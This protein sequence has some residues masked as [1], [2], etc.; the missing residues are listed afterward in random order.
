M[1]TT[2]AFKQDKIIAHSLALF[3]HKIAHFV[4]GKSRLRNLSYKSLTLQIRCSYVNC[5][6]GIVI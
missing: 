4:F 6:N 2:F 5:Y 3:L 1:G